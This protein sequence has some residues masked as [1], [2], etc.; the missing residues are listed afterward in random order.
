[1][2]DHFR[3]NNNA[4]GLAEFAYINWQA[5]QY[6]L[7]K[8]KTSVVEKFGYLHPQNSTPPHLFIYTHLYVGIKQGD[9]YFGY[10]EEMNFLRDD[11]IFAV[12]KMLLSDDIVQEQSFIEFPADWHQEPVNGRSY[13]EL[14]VILTLKNDV[15]FEEAVS[16]IMG[17]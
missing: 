1:M 16:R 12:Q 14:L 4:L 17:S 3:L 13:P 9:K 8:C 5:E 15:D 7:Q 11:T 6:T 10:Y 2:Y